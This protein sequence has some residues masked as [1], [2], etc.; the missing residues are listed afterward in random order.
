[1]NDRVAQLKDRVIHTPPEV[2]NDRLRAITASYQATEGLP[3]VLRRAHA[4]TRILA[5]M[6]IYILDGEL[7][8]GNQAF[9]PKAAPWFPEFDVGWI[10]REIDDLGTRR[11]DPFR[12]S[13]V[14]KEEA[15]G[16]LPYWRGK[17]HRDL[18]LKKIDASLSDDMK[19][20]YDIYHCSINQTL[21]NLYH[22]ITGD[23]HIIADY[24]RVLNHGLGRLREQAVCRLEGDVDGDQADFLRAVI[25]SIDAVIQFAHRFAGHAEQKARDEQDG[26]RKQELLDIARVCRT[27]P[28]QPAASLHE[29]LQSLWFTHLVI[30]IESNGQSIS[31][32]RFDQLMNPYY[33]RDKERTSLS[34]EAAIE[35]IQCFFL[36]AMEVNKVRDWGSTEFNTGYAMYQTLTLGGQTRD[37]RDATNEMTYLALEAT[38]DLKVQEPTT[39][40]RVHQDTP[41]ELLAA[42]VKALAEHRGGLPSFFNDDVAVPLMLNQPHNDISLEDAR[43]WAVM[44]CVEPN[45]PG[46]YLPSTGGT[47]VINLAKAF[48]IAFN[49][50]LNPETGIRVFQPDQAAIDSY[51]D[52]WD[53]YR[54][55][56]EYYM[57]LIPTLMQA[58]C[59]A[60]R[61]LTPTPFLSALVS[62]RIDMARDLFEG[63]GPNDYNVELMEIHG[64]GTATDALAAVKIAVFDE[65][66]FTLDELRTM[67]RCNFESC[68]RERLYLQNRVAKYGNDVEQVDA[69]ARQI[70]DT[71]S[72]YMSQ[73]ATPRKGGYGISTQTTTC[74]V[75]DGKLVGATPDGRFAQDPLS[76]N[77]SP[78][79]AA[80]R[81]GPTAA[82][83][84]VAMTGH[85]KIGM[86]S[87]FNMKFTPMQ[88]TT[89]AGRR[90]FADL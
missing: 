59:D 80:D 55:Q 49:D 26:T 9:Q 67:T 16:L 15:K 2:C 65:G 30:Q 44:G 66:R 37:G 58:T 63:R 84:S 40:L 53:A 47:C 1:M 78:S 57:D 56:L 4:L 23:G 13:D 64:L 21:G 17:T 72:S 36:K 19:Q 22:T 12:I 18:C 48:E 11:L 50:G 62:D 39:V 3:I 69:I 87:L 45:V 38:A 14:I 74:N 77:H 28:E 90:K 73:F 86:G 33:L 32:G 8:V 52:L 31:F 51:E 88:F 89:E 68:E 85:D 75:P 43:D 6:R 20:H 54:E 5:D 76:D 29:A 60:Y 34:W 25:L 79:P 42:A 24:G 70:I 7:I 83:K 81:S 41:D 10:E 61:E 35:L 46:K 27:V 71:V 82:M